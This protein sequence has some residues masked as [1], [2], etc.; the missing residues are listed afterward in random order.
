MKTLE[1]EMQNKANFVI[2]RINE[3]SML[4]HGRLSGCGCHI[5]E[6]GLMWFMEKFNRT[7]N[8]ILPIPYMYPTSEGN[9]MVEWSFDGY[10]ISLEVDVVN[11]LAEYQE[12]CVMN[13]TEKTVDIDLSDINDWSKLNKMLVTIYNK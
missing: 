7:F 2:S 13:E 5:D 9:L 3:L 6:N 12:I 4:Q 8:F 11:K 1:D 10:E